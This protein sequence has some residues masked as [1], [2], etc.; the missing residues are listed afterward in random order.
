MMKSA[1]WHLP[2][3]PFLRQF[4]GTEAINNVPNDGRCFFAFTVFYP[5]FPAWQCEAAANY[6]VLRV[7]RRLCASVM[8]IQGVSEVA[9]HADFYENTYK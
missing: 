7:P 1:V 5:H 4:N 6:L 9:H 3:Q 2:W 8:I